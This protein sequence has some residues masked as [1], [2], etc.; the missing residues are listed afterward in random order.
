[1]KQIGVTLVLVAAL[2]AV[3][4]VARNHAQQ[5][6]EQGAREAVEHYLKGHATGDPKEFSAAFHEQARL[7]WV[8]AEGKLTTRTSAEYIAGARGNPA[9]DE[10]KRKR[11]IVSLD[12]TRTAG[13]A[14]VELDY[15]GS[16]F[17]DYLALLKINGEWK[18]INKIFTVERRATD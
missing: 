5:A 7:F 8:D 12:V 6:D 11:R 17:I 9:A 13:V 14:K 10:S 18:V 4:G 1:M 3:G 2:A 16:H 15:P